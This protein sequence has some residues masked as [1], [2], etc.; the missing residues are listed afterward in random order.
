MLGTSPNV[1]FT[2]QLSAGNG[3]SVTCRFSIHV[4][5]EECCP[6]Q[7]FSIKASFSDVEISEEEHAKL[8][9]MQDIARTI[10]PNDVRQYDVTMAQLALEFIRMSHKIDYGK[11]RKTRRQSSD[12]EK[13]NFSCTIC[14]LTF[15][16]TTLLFNH[17]SRCHI[18]EMQ[19]RVWQIPIR[20]GCV[21][22]LLDTQKRRDNIYFM[23]SR[24]KSGM[25]QLLL[26][27]VWPLLWAHL[28]TL[29]SSMLTWKLMI[30]W[31]AT[32]ICSNV[33]IAKKWVRIWAASEH[34][35]NTAMAE[36]NTCVQ[37]A[38][39]HR[40]VSRDSW[41][42]TDIAASVPKTKFVADLSLLIFFLTRC[43]LQRKIL[44]CSCLT[45]TLPVTIAVSSFSAQQRGINT[46]LSAKRL[47]KRTQERQV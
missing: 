7:M 40:E 4:W 26:S 13:R 44:F 8:T 16:D 28:F 17:L 36:A 39:V 6:N 43:K 30:V 20:S 5:D 34:T 37:T 10:P 42:N 29:S 47:R 33:L 9:Q 1:S 24:R 23:S 22:R 41:P 38:G 12:T 31:H 46:C 45:Q 21:F 2:S 3:D 32:C 18:K 35:W 15:V 27:Q 25:H 19:E 14:G 11:I